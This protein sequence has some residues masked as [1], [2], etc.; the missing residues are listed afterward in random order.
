MAVGF[1]PSDSDQNTPPWYK[2]V[3][4]PVELRKYGFTSKD[5]A[6]KE[7]PRFIPDFLATRPKRDGEANDLSTVN[8]NEFLPFAQE[9]RTASMKGHR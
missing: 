2:L 3:N 6:L 1:A 7:L 9:K 5:D 4:D 8:W